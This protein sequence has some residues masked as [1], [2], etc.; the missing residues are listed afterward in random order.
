MKVGT[1]TPHQGAFFGSFGKRGVGRAVVVH[2]A[3]YTDIPLVS[4]AHGGRH[5]SGQKTIPSMAIVHICSSY[6]WVRSLIIT[7]GGSLS[8]CACSS[9]LRDSKAALHG[10]SVSACDVLAQIQG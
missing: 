6:E 2:H 10:S 4:L 9:R 3:T 1:A 7:N 8:F 5:P